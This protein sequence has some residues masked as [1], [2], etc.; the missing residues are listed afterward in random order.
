MCFTKYE[1]RGNQWNLNEGNGV[2]AMVTTLSNYPRYSFQKKVN[3]FETA[4]FITVVQIIH[5]SQF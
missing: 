2:Q 4:S 3:K 5:S 1:N